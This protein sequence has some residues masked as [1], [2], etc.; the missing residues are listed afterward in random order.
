MFADSAKFPPVMWETFP[1]ET[2]PHTSDWSFQLKWNNATDNEL[3][4]Q[5]APKNTWSQALTWQVPPRPGP[6][7]GKRNPKLCLSGIKRELR[8]NNTPFNRINTVTW[9]VNACMWWTKKSD[10][11]NGIG[12]IA[13][14]PPTS[15]IF[16][17]QAGLVKDSAFGAVDC[18]AKKWMFW[19]HLAKIGCNWIALSENISCGRPKALI[20]SLWIYSPKEWNPKKIHAQFKCEIIASRWRNT[21][22]NTLFWFDTGS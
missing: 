13:T 2:V 19:I 10:V 9:I 18:G 12:I 17:P 3:Y 5:N 6:S 16:P 22:S 20:V 7:Q 1:F 11:P 8:A 15:T 21:L 14:F 4:I